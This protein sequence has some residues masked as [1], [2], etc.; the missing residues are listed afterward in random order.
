MGRDKGWTP[1]PDSV[2]R[3]RRLAIP[4]TLGI[5]PP[6][7]KST[8]SATAPRHPGIEAGAFERRPLALSAAT[9]SNGQTAAEAHS[10]QLR[11]A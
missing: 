3:A 5:H 2:R 10:N 11:A 8:L 9:M 1:T 6:D 4:N 7:L